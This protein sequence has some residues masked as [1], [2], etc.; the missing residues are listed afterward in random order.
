[1][2]LY[3]LIYSLAGAILGS[4]AAGSLEAYHCGG[5]S[6]VGGSGKLEGVVAGHTR[7]EGSGARLSLRLGEMISSRFVRRKETK[8]YEENRS[9]LRWD[10]E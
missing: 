1:M 9:M 7:F 4:A 8:R 6:G 3:L 10:L 2:I 5:S